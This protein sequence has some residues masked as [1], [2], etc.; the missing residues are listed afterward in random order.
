[1]PL[2]NNRFRQMNKTLKNFLFPKLTRRFLLRIFLLITA[3]YVFFGHICRPM[4]VEGISMEPTYRDG[5][6]TFCWRPAFRG[7]DPQNGELVVIRFAGR[8]AALLKRVIGTG[9]DVLEFR[10][11]VLYRNGEAVHEVYLIK[12]SDWNMPPRL[13]KEGHF[14]VVGDNRSMHIDNHLFG[15]VVRHRILGVPLL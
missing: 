13:V 10:D 4:R 3:S 6:I 14:Y 1:M 11:G 2:I 15:E 5:K 8:Q 9:G 12:P 7:R